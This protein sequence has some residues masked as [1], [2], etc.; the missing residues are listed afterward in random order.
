LDKNG[1]TPLCHAVFYGF[2]E[3]ARFLFSMGARPDASKIDLLSLAVWNGDPDI[4]E[5]VLASQKV[6]ANGKEYVPVSGE[7]ATGQAALREKV[8]I[9]DKIQEAVQI[10]WSAFRVEAV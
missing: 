9:S 7:F 1:W 10:Y 5:P 2:N 3:I 4:I 8:V 6:E